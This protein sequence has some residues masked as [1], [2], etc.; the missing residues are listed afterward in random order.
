MPGKIKVIKKFDAVPTKKKAKAPARTT[1]REVVT[2]VS[3]W[4]TD[5]RDRKS[6]E[7]K[8]AIDSLFSA[9]PRPSES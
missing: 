9:G 3:E 5:L 6:K 1:A 8:A 2:T 4:V 7:T